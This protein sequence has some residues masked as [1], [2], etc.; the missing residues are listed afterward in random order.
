ML[1]FNKNKYKKSSDLQ[2]IDEYKRSGDKLIIGELFERYSPLVYGVC[3]KYLK[4]TAESKDALLHIFENLFSEL[5]KYE[6]LNFK[7][8]LYK[9]TKNQCL[10]IIR[11]KIRTAEREKKYSSELIN[12]QPDDEIHIWEEHIGFI[13]IAMDDLKEEQKLCIDLFYLKSKSY[14]EIADETNFSLDQVKSYIQNGK[15]NL[16]IIL[17]N[18]EI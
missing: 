8:W 5:L 7:N 2:L 14:K 3:L 13:S 4:N 6:I 9:S 1:F 16:K 10:M 12:E 17:E 11:Q 15:R 18:K